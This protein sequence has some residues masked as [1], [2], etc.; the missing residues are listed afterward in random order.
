MKR[1]LWTALSILVLVAIV[2]A[3]AAPAAPGATGELSGGTVIERTEPVQEM[4]G[5]EGF[6]LAAPEENPKHGGILKTA[7]GANPTHF[8]IHQGG[9]WSGGN[10][11]YDGLVLWNLLDG[12]GSIIPGLA[13]S[14]DVSDDKTVYTFHLR[15]GVKFHDGSDFDSAD[16]VATFQRIIAP[17]DTIA[18]GSLKEQLAM[19]DTIAAPDA[20]TV[21]FTLKRP[22]PFFLEILA[23]DSAVIFS[24]EELA[25]NNN[26]LRGVTVP[27]GTGPFKFVEFIPGE[28]IVIEANPDYWNPNLP[29]VDGIEFLN[30]GAWADRGTA[31]LTGQADFSF[32]VSADTWNEGATRENLGT[33]RAPCL[34]SHMVAINN[35]HSPWTI[36]L[37]ARPSPWPLTARR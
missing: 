13:T 3:C 33:A 15:E 27:T 7:W 35:E 9:G 6:L 37:S 17:P 30:V 26:D 28:K 11:M 34:N 18:I 1:G 5:G 20:A 25:A 23:G 8:D 4:T 22:T 36:P 2:A 32:N 10:M 24:A 31:V 21:V 29:Y 14:W 16:V 19:V 12:Y